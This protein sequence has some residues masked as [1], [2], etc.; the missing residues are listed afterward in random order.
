MYSAEDL[1]YFKQYEQFFM[2]YQEIVTKNNNTVYKLLLVMILK[3]W[4]MMRLMNANY[5]TVI[6]YKN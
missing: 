4:E 2:F 5:H 3:R 1:S 6:L